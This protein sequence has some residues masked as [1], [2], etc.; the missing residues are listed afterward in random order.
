MTTYQ[1]LI[2]IISVI[3]MAGCS[4]NESK[5]IDN[6][7]VKEYIE[8]LSQNQYDS[9]NLPAFT[10]KDIPALLEFRN[11]TQMITNYPTNFISSL[12]LPKCKLGIYI[13][14]TIESIRAV[15]INSEYLVMRFPSQNPI[16]AYKDTSELKL[17]SDNESHIA[18]A[19]A[20]YDWWE[21]NKQK[22][23]DEFK[24]IDPL[25]NTKYKWH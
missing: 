15:A 22:N 18:A 10:Y 1:I 5:E 14:W 11:D 4:K 3:G 20:Y 23:F 9:A 13:L 12:A 24:D 8:L 21:N 16:L 25:E 7:D 6:I 19:N 2:T 17:V